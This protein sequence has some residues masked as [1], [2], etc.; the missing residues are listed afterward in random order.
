MRLVNPDRG[1]SMDL[2]EN[3]T[4]VLVMESKK[5]FTETI[6]EFLAQGEGHEGG[7]VLSDNDRELPITKAVDLLL[8]PFELDFQ[9]KKIISRL[10]QEL[11]AIANEEMPADLCEVN[12]AAIRLLDALAERSPY[13]ITYH[14]E[15]D[16]SSILKLYAV[17]IDGGEGNFL[18]TL[19]DYIK[20]MTHLCGI[21]LFALV[22][23]STYLDEPD[24]AGLY[25]VAAYEKA[26]ILLLE[27]ST[28]RWLDCE[29]VDIIDEDHC[30]IHL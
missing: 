16:I 28:R 1:I 23:L 25:E 24:L 4:H 11:G 8:T 13:A 27:N 10:Y 29:I 19:C 26:Q 15:T 21:R 18:E 2:V 5:D 17:G 6:A 7:F 30:L 12:T 9:N 3:K 22:N 14:L 20:V